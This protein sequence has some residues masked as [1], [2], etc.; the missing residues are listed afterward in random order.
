MDKYE[1]KFYKNDEEIEVEDLPDEYVNSVIQVCQNEM[2][3]RNR[4]QK[5][6]ERMIIK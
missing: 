1:I 5:V 3:S 4:L 6:I 2:V